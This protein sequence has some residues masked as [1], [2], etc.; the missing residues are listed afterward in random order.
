MKMFLF[1]ETCDNVKYKCWAKFWGVG[2]YFVAVCTQHSNAT[3]TQTNNEWNETLFCPF[4]VLLEACLTFV[5]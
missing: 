1:K 4:L 2:Q 5:T 3:A